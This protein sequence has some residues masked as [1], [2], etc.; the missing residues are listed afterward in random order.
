MSQ[1]RIPLKTAKGFTMVE[2][3]LFLALSSAVLIGLLAGTS[4]SIARQ[5]YNDATQDLNSFL[6]RQY[7]GVLN[8]QNSLSVGGGQS[9]DKAIYGR[10][11]V[12]PGTHSASGSHEIHAWNVV[13]TAFSSDQV[14]QF[15]DTKTALGATNLMVACGSLETYAT[16]WGSTVEE[17]DS[18]NPF[19]GSILIIRSPLT[20]II[21]TYYNS[22]IVFKP[23]DSCQDGV[24]NT[25]LEF[26][27]FTDIDDIN[28]CLASP[29]KLY[30]GRRRNIRIDKDNHSINSINLIPL[31]DLSKNKCK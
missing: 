2:V 16:Q 17:T 14:N 6:Q 5:R 24:S 15:T 21:Y 12:F 19:T 20:G 7:S 9:P 27:D 31:D 22:D 29:D 28:F 10:L 8:V 4:S 18:N 1:P 13:G 26:A 11:I 25:H 30:G 3:I 23:G